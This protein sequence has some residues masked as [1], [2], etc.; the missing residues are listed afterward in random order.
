VSPSPAD[1]GRAFFYTNT[2]HQRTPGTVPPLDRVS[3][4]AASSLRA[5]WFAVPCCPPNVARLLAS[6]G[7]Y[8]ATT[9]DTGLQLH[10]YADTDIEA[11]LASGERVGLQVR[12]R[13][14]EDG[15]IRV[16][17]TQA[18]GTQWTLRLRV[19]AWATAGASLEVEG[20]RRSVQPGEVEVTRSFAVGDVL[21]LD[22]PVR[23]RWTWADP[24]IDAARGQVAVERGPIVMC[25]ESTDLGHDVEDVRV[26]V[27][28]EPLERDGEVLV[29]VLTMPAAADDWPY[30]DRPSGSLAEGRPRLVALTPYHRWASRGPCTMRVW[31]PVHGI[32]PESHM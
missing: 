30:R 13:Y 24:R 16:E 32:W 4:R 27:D 22:L 11:S 31:L 12:T 17:V 19:P 2:L 25:L 20:E 14:P 5:P 23:A 26:L 7:S 1:D 15:R 3:P 9:D 28:D 29:P 8:L 18:P 6:L 21:E 10:Q